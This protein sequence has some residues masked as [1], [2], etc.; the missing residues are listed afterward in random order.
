[1]PW[2]HGRPALEGRCPRGCE[3]EVLPAPDLGAESSPTDDG[4]TDR[5]TETAPNSL[6]REPTVTRR[7]AAATQTHRGDGS[8]S[9]SVRRWGGWGLHDPGPTG[10]PPP[11]GWDPAAGGSGESRSRE[12]V[13]DRA[14]LSLGDLDRDAGSA[15][16]ER[17]RAGGRDGKRQRAV[18]MGRSRQPGEAPPTNRPS[19]PAHCTTPL[20]T[21]SLASAR[22]V[23]GWK[24]RNAG[25]KSSP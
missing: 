24:W 20:G 17:W 4:W 13:T 14:H 6:P 23:L 19:L 3:C 21:H 5:P 7:S 1:M 25:P 12:A 15:A 9:V 10:L 22:R 8:S 2:G 16:S 11:G 18:P